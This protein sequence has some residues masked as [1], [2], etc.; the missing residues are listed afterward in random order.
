MQNNKTYKKINMKTKIS[1]LAVIKGFFILLVMCCLFSCN[2]TA[3]DENKCLES[4]KRC[5]P[6]SKIYKQPGQSF[7]F[8]VVDSTGVKKVTTL[9][10]YSSNIDGITEFVVVK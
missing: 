10:V 5:F 8:Y 9:N 2:S 3:A 1:I 4:V 7:T 6:K